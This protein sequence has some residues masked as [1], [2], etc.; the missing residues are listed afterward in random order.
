MNTS[1]SGSKRLNFGLIGLVILFIGFLIVLITFL[2][3]RYQEK[4]K[5]Q[6]TPEPINPRIIIQE[7]DEN[8][9]E[10]QRTTFAEIVKS[11]VKDYGYNLKV[12]K[13]IAG[14]SAHETGR[15]KSDLA[16]KYFNIFGMKSG[17]GGQN[18]QT[19]TAKGFA[20]Y[21]DY[22]DS[23]R[24]LD[25]WLV[26]KGFNKS[27]DLDAENYLQWIKSK[28]YFEDTLQNYKTSV[29]SLINELS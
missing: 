21:K 4:R 25:A 12:A 16:Q 28:K 7:T 5:L 11:L 22:E 20:V 9:I 18:I 14:Q 19:G 13:A 29:L 3:K 26:A 1:N 23:L 10:D 24:D 17:G 27:E 2:V 8:T 6:I 15:W